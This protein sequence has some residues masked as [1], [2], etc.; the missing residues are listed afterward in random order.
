MKLNK[1]ILASALVL[2]YFPAS[3]QEATEKPQYDFKGHWYI[4]AM[5]GAQYT[6]GETDFAD[7]IS[8]NAQLAVGYDF[9]PNLGLRLSVNAWQSKGGTDAISNYFAKQTY[10][11]NYVAPTVDLVFNLSNIIAGYNPQR[12]VNVS[13]FGGIGANFAFGNDEANDLKN[14]YYKGIWAPGFEPM[15]YCWE[16][17]TSVAGKFGAIFDIRLTDNWRLEVEANANV[18]DDHYNSK[19]AG[20]S[21]WYFNA[22]AGLKYNFGKYVTKREPVKLEPETIYVEK[23][24]VKE[25][26]KEVIKEVVKMQPL[27]RDVFFTI[28]SS[29]ISNAEMQKVQDVIAY[30]NEYPAS[31]VSVTGYADSATGNASINAKFAEQR[32]QAVYDVLVKNGIDASRITKDSKGGQLELFG[33]NPAKNRV[34][35]CVAAE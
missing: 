21:D 3:A 26:I 14:N 25:V 17:E 22:L 5:G 16:N 35:I 2:G 30:M 11:W 28:G 23:P 27:R 29:R 33:G 8:P 19:K 7:L 20:N 9:N 12:G 18:V 13:I 1:I 34:A 10:K 24:V 6:L 31:K 32:A 15:R 4:E